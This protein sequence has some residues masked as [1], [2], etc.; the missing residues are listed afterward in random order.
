MY[1]AGCESAQVRILETGSSDGTP[2]MNP[3][4][5]RS[6]G[7]TVCPKFWSWNLTPQYL[8]HVTKLEEIAFE[9]SFWG[10]LN[11]IWLLLYKKGISSESSHEDTAVGQWQV[12]AWSRLLHC[13]QKEPT[14]PTSWSDFRVPELRYKFRRP[15]QPVGALYA[16]SHG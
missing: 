6:A 5:G 11:P 9:R 2:Q 8:K 14:R 3:W 1:G 13:P 15:R 7:R 12:E 4:A 16:I 10:V